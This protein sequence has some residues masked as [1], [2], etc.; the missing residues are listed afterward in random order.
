MT[1]KLLNARR[2]RAAR[3]QAGGRGPRAGKLDEYANQFSPC[4]A[5]ACLDDDAEAAAAEKP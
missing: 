1:L 4:D 2:L 3:A 5:G